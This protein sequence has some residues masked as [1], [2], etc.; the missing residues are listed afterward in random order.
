MSS[1]VITYFESLKLDIVNS[2]IKS[3]SGDEPLVVESDASNY[4]LAE[5]LI[6]NGRPLA[7]FSR[8]LSNCEK[9]HPSI[10]KEAYAIV[11][12]LRKRRHFL[13]GRQFKLIIDQEAVPFVLNLKYSSKIINDKIILDG[14]L[15]VHVLD[16]MYNVTQEKKIQ[17]LTL[18][19]EYVPL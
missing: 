14:D 16:L 19:Q 13:I 15:N 7:F 1:S 10:E 18:S 3:I 9:K 12:E 11:E 5:K 8:S 6:Q 4:A 17:L 2:V